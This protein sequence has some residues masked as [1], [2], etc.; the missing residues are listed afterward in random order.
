MCLCQ[1][2]RG[3]PGQRT[4]N[5][6]RP[7]MRPTHSSGPPLIIHNSWS[8]NCTHTHKHTQT[9]THSTV[10]MTHM[11]VSMQ[12]QINRSGRGGGGA[13]GEGYRTYVEHT[14]TQHIQHSHTCRTHTCTHAHQMHTL[15]K[16]FQT[17]S[18]IFLSSTN[19]NFILAITPN[20]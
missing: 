16:D 4:H 11:Y 7:S 18:F 2:S 10:D 19:N 20:P 6:P 8:F 17:C 9:H 12:S 14:Y 15:N 3:D 5:A 13:G 1:G